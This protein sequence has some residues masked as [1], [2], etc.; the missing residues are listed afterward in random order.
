[1]VPFA[2]VQRAA[3]HMAPLRRSCRRRARRSTPVRYAASTSTSA[4]P[5]S[6]GSSPS[7]TAS[8]SGTCRWCSWMLRTGWTPSSSR[9]STSLWAPSSTGRRPFVRFSMV[10]TGRRPLSPPAATSIPSHSATARRTFA[11]SGSCR[12]VR[13]CPGAPP[14]LRTRAPAAHRLPGARPAAGAR[15]AGRGPVRQRRAR[16]GGRRG[17]RPAAGELT[18]EAVGS[19]WARPRRAVVR[20]AAARRRPRSRRWRPPTMRRCGRGARA[21]G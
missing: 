21:A 9:L 2:A 19:R 11:S 4:R 6:R 3:E 13:S 1:M 12:R 15:T 20:E 16:R 8:G 17:G 18:A 5:A 10:S 14:S 7:E